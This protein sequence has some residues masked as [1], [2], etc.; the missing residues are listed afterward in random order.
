MSRPS[1]E[2]SAPMKHSDHESTPANPT[3][4][5]RYL[6]WPVKRL[7]FAV[8]RPVVVPDWDAN[9][10]YFCVMCG[11]PVLRRFLTCSDRCSDLFNAL[12]K[13]TEGESG[14]A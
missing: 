11:E 8:L 1:R 10:D 13:G 6:L 4:A 3:A 14:V 5:R 12:G 9:E 7:V 2:M